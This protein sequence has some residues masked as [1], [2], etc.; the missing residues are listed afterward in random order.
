[1]RTFSVFGTVLHDVS[2]DELLARLFDVRGLV[3]TPN[4]EILLAA[5]SHAEYRDLLNCAALSLPDGIATVFAVAALYD[6]HDFHRNTGID[7]IQIVARVAEQRGET[8]IFLG[9]YSADHDNLRASFRATHPALR[10]ICID[11]GVIAEQQFAVAHEHLRTIQDAG[12]AIL[13][14]GLGQGRGRTQGKQEAIANGILHAAP[15]VRFAIGVGGSIDVLSGRVNR[16]PGQFQRFGFEWMWRLFVSP[17]RFSRIFRAV[18]VFPILIA[19]DTLKQGK[20]LRACKSVAHN[21]VVHF[22]TKPV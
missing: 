17:W 18:V 19:W 11:P 15:N 20:F 16:A 3:V 7:T 6:V 1:M 8:I 4:P 9:G 12:A 14:V 5:K 22:F 10:V 2:G 21:L 13:L